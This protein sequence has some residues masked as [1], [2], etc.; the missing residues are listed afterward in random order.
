MDKNNAFFNKIDSILIDLTNE[1][2]HDTV[3][4]LPKTSKSGNQKRVVFYLLIYLKI[5]FSY[6]IIRVR[7][8]FFNYHIFLG[9]LIILQI[10]LFFKRKICSK[11]NADSEYVNKNGLF[12]FFKYFLYHW[13][14]K[15]I[16]RDK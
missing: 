7:V 8:R 13:L 9:Q 12:F 10:Y 14:Y 6:S 3:Y 16:L 4:N 11:L 1:D 5:R 15:L 2:V